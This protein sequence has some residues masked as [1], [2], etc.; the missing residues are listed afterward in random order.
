MLL[1]LC[2]IVAMA[3]MFF[4][5]FHKAKFARTRR[6]ALLPLAGA[7]MEG[8]AAGALTP[9]LFPV[10]TAA[11][12]VLRLAILLCCAGAMRQDA[13][14]ARRRSRIRRRM[15]AEMAKEAIVTLP[16]ARELPSAGQGRRRAAG[17]C[18]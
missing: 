7:V 5:M 3:G 9:G 12:V 4:Y 18:A 13:A 8:I 10:L 11:L 14:M 2:S 15:A 17:R 16:V 1:S 6:M